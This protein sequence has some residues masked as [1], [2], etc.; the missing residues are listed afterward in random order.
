MKIRDTKFEV[1][2]LVTPIAMPMD[3]WDHPNAVLAVVLDIKSPSGAD[4]PDLP[5]C[6]DI[7]DTLTL[8]FITGPDA[9]P[10]GERAWDC[11]R[12]YKKVTSMLENE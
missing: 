2:D 5:G 1:G 12:Y 3:K 11:A 9:V 4:L 10:G 7:G 6:A 8:R